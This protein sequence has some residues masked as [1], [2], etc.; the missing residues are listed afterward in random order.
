M[1]GRRPDGDKQKCCIRRAAVFRRIINSGSA[2]AVISISCTMLH[3]KGVICVTD[4]GS[5]L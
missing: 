2:P 1:R 3:C 5:N 4:E